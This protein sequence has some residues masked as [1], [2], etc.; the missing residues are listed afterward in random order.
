MVKKTPNHPGHVF[1]ENPNTGCIVGEKIRS[2]D[3]HNLSWINLAFGR[4]T[5]VPGRVNE[6]SLEGGGAV[7]TDRS[8]ATGKNLNG[9]KEFRGPSTKSQAR[10]FGKTG[11]GSS[12]RHGVPIAPLNGENVV[13]QSGGSDS[14]PALFPEV[15][16]Q[17]GGRD[18]DNG[19][20][21]GPSFADILSKQSKTTAK[22]TM[23]PA[24]KNP[25]I[26][27]GEEVLETESFYQEHALI[28][29]FAGLWPSLP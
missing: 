17:G 18:T 1:G 6:I 24:E 28:C 12:S 4:D 14:I 15:L 21:S 11:F 20:S 27:F 23:K 26:T 29:R 2:A 10:G 7:S 5:P 25:C 13:W 19:R 9:N 8:V 16:N 22:T 3:S